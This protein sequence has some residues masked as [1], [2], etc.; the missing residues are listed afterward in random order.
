MRVEEQTKLEVK[1][2][3]IETIQEYARNPKK[4]SEEQ[5]E[6]VARSISSF[7]W[8][9]AIIVDKAGVIIAGHSRYRAAKALGMK[10]V[11]VMVASDMTED[12]VSAYRIADNKVAESEWD[13]KLLK[14]ELGSLDLRGIDMTLTGFDLEELKFEMNAI[15]PEPVEDNPRT[16]REVECPHCGGTFAPQK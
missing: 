7:G 3:S 10:T 14:F 5:I 13:T 16:S 6:K 11:P 2:Q 12:Q 15:D 9:T 1:W 8:R 4:H